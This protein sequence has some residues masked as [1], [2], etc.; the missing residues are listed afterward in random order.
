MFNLKVT[1]SGVAFSLLSHIKTYPGSLTVIVELSSKAG[2][3]GSRPL[4]FPGQSRSVFGIR[5][6]ACCNFGQKPDNSNRLQGHHWV[7]IIRPY[8]DDCN[9]SPTHLHHLLH[10]YS[11]QGADERYNHLAG[12][13]VMLG[14]AFEHNGGGDVQEVAA[15]QGIKKYHAGLIENMCLGQ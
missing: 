9:I 10:G 12:V 2:V 5:R 1:S 15:D 6:L 14:T 3:R 7:L 13:E 8:K 11:Q 4:R